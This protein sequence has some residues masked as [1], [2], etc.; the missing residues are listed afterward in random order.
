MSAL[1]ALL[2]TLALVLAAAYLPGAL[3]V[4]VLG[5][6]RLLSLA[7]A[8]AI[9]AAI[10]GGAALLA[11]ALGVRW[12]LLPFLGAALLLIAVAAALRRLGVRLPAT[13]L[14]GPLAPRRA[15]PGLGLWMTGAVLVALGPI[16][17]QAGRADAVLERW[18]TLYHLSALARIRETGN[19]SSLAVGAI[20]QSSGDPSAYPAGFHALAS[21][22]PAVGI[23]VQLNGA[24]LALS[25]VPWLLGIALLARAVFPRIPW[26]P[27]AAALAA[28][29]VPAAPWDEWIHLSAIP[30][31]AGAAAIPGML[32]AAAALW[33]A[34]LARL[35]GGAEEGA[36]GRTL[37]AVLGVLALA[38]IGLTLLHPNTAVTTLLLL[39]ALTAG[40]TAGRW[41]RCPWLAAVP[42]A[43]LLP[44]LVMTYSS[45]GGHVTAFEG[46]LR[47]S[48][49]TGLGE[50]VL[51]LLT[52][53]PMALGVLLAPLWWAG[54]VRCAGRRGPHW[55]V[56]AW[57]VIAVLY[58]DAAIDAPADLSA[59]YYR[60]QDRIAMTLAM[61]CA[62]LVVPG[63][64]LLGEALR[65]RLS[66]RG[67]SAAGGSGPG[68]AGLPRAAVVV[69]VALAVLAA[70]SS[71]PTR[72]DNAA[73][74]LAA[75][76]P[77]RGRFL[78]ADER[79]L[80]AQ[81]APQMDPDGVILASPYSGAAHL[82]AL[83]GLSV[84]L[85][86]LGMSYSDLDRDLLYATEDAAT[87][88]AS[89]AL[90]QEH[91]IRYV[92]QETQPYQRHKTSDSVN[93]ASE[94]LGPV[95][96][97]TGHSRMIEVDCDAS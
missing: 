67:D 95:L 89:C 65:A 66:A 97:A 62:V 91:G 14:D 86:V 83:Y 46:G 61:L 64:Q 72:L 20:S 79:A 23:P 50:I 1:L 42:L 18:D 52:V 44:Y 85:P 10:A 55:L 2:A 53:W 4:R 6:S 12:S 90:L 59:L 88:P 51:G 30:N 54:L 87:N 57:L 11:P 19:A 31:V 60:G 24:M 7:L 36:T 43:M 33:G 81:H 48:A 76:Y 15:V 49:L 8:P 38:G 40:T 34:L 63:L 41:R 77:G 69:A 80:F 35:D 37:L 96:F 3:A 9:G 16:A 5:G 26:A 47:V 71:V 21:L 92:Y 32:A 39:A 75:D 29:L 73:K 22:V 45:L 78:Q 94:E 13:V 27:G 17:W 74:N 28:A 84:R 93:L 58:F 70:G 56:L 82:Y 25:V 68:R